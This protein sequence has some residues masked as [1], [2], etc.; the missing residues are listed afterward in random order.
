MFCS[1]RK[2]IVLSSGGGRSERGEGKGGKGGW[3]GE[4]EAKT[5]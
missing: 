2:Q 4:G 3:A 5:G 1:S